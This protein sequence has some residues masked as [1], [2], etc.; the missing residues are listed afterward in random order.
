MIARRLMDRLVRRKMLP[1]VVIAGAS[2]FAAD[3]VVAQNQP[4]VS[5]GIRYVAGQKTSLVVL[6]A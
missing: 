1:A 3:V 5:L 4:G 6:P 2:M